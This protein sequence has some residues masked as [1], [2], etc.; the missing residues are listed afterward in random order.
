MT[1]ASAALTAIALLLARPPSRWVV[2]SRL[3]VGVDAPRRTPSLAAPIVLVVLGVGATVALLTIGVSTAH[4]ITGLTAIG[5]GLFWLR[6][7]RI[8]RES[9]IRSLGRRQAAEIV[10]ALAAELGGGILAS[11]ALR[12]LA[13]DMELL[14][15]AATA[16]RLGGD[17]PGAL[18]A[19]S[20]RPGAES[21]GGLAAAWEV[22]ERSGAPMAR[23]LARLGH[24]IRD[25]LESRREIQA[26]L[27]PARATARLM[28]VLPLFGI[29]LGMSMGARP[30]HTLLNTAFG[31]LCLA[32]GTALACTGVWWVDRIAA[33]AERV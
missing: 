20:R 17:V 32:A 22:S 8:S 15:G 27:A 9:A 4:L 16:A 18:R 5:V 24:G 14:D 11:H 23:V 3:G 1:Y 29:G 33:R 21:L 26:G 19:A 6:L 7:H 30:L 31:A 13:A 25:E 2:S 28:A 10:D 12:D